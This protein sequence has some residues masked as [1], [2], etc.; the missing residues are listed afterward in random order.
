MYKYIIIV[1]NN[2]FNSFR[3]IYYRNITYLL[4]LQFFFDLI[5]IKLK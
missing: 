2:Y 4:F 5:N 3:I 1:A